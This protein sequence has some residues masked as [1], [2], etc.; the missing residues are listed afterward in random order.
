MLV[1]GR[2]GLTP[3]LTLTPKQRVGLMATFRAPPNCHMTRTL[4]A[5]AALL[6]VEQR[7]I[8]QMDEQ[9]VPG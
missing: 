3:R 9:T 1:G 5:T 2:L 8:P 4:T 7:R 6:T